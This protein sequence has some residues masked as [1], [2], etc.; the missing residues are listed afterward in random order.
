MFIDKWCGPLRTEWLEW[1]SAVDRAG[2]KHVTNIM[3]C[4]FASMET[5]VKRHIKR[6]ILAAKKKVME[7]NDV[8]FYWLSNWEE[9]ASVLLYML[10]SEYVK[11]RGHSTA[12]AWLES[13]GV[14]KQLISNSTSSSKESPSSNTAEDQLATLTLHNFCLISPYK[15]HSNVWW[16]LNKNQ[17]RDMLAGD[18]GHHKINKLWWVALL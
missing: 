1:M 2:L 6:V 18:N 12:S 3:Y 8:L 10:V 11:I 5:E 17:G 9:V 16:D 7:S 13:K 14:R 4:M 15:A